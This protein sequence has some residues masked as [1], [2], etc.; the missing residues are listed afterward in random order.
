MVLH[1]MNDGILKASSLEGF[2]RSNW[3]IKNNGIF[4]CCSLADTRWRC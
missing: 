1:L 4:I 2:T 3:I